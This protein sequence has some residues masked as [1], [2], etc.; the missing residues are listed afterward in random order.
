MDPPALG[1]VSCQSALASCIHSRPHPRGA[2]GPRGP[3]YLGLLLVAGD[4]ADLSRRLA[5]QGLQASHAVSMHGSHGRGMAM[6]GGWPC[7]G[8]HGSAWEGT[9]PPPCPHPR[10]LHGLPQDP[11]VGGAQGWAPDAQGLPVPGVRVAL[12]GLPVALAAQPRQEHRFCDSHRLCIEEEGRPSISPDT[13]ESTHVNAFTW[14]HAQRTETSPMPF[15]TL[16][17]S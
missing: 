3:A 13:Y 5:G 4:A 11:L 16:M 8:V 7:R 17:L 9:P 14:M 12:E 2:R 6:Q 15:D 10:E 1:P